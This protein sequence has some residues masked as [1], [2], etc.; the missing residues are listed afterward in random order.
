MQWPAIEPTL[1]ITLPLVAQHAH[2]RIRFQRKA[3]AQLQAIAGCIAAVVGGRMM[4]CDGNC[5][6]TDGSI[7][8]S[9]SIWPFWVF[10]RGSTVVLLA[11]SL[12]GRQ[13]RLAKRRRRR[14]GEQQASD[15]SQFHVSRPPRGSAI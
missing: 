14:E 6:R 4:R 15:Q 8:S 3:G 12:R 1:V 5:G 10:H 2:A 11:E 7:S 9:A 13:I